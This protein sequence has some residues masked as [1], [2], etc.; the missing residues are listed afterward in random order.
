MQ[1]KKDNSS[2]LLLLKTDFVSFSEKLGRVW[3]PAI[4]KSAGEQLWNDQYF[5]TSTPAELFQAGFSL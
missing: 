1:Q 5:Q 4:T 3:C 2:R